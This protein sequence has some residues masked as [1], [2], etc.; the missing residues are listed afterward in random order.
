MLGFGTSAFMI[1]TAFE[2]WANDPTITTLETIAAPISDVQFPTV[3]VCNNQLENPPD[4]WGMLENVMNLMPFW[5]SNN[6]TC[7]KAKDI[8]E[9]I[10][11]LTKHV[12]DVFLD[13]L[14]H[15]ENLEQSSRI[16]KDPTSIKERQQI[17]SRLYELVQNGDFDMEKLKESP[18]DYF[19]KPFDIIMKDIGIEEK[20]LSSINCTN[21][22]LKIRAISDLIY[23]MKFSTLPLRL[24]SFLRNFL[25]FIQYDSLHPSKEIDLSMCKVWQWTCKANICKFKKEESRLHSMFENIS[26][27]MGFKE[28]FSL[29]ELPGLLGFLEKRFTPSKFHQIFMYQRC[30]RYPFVSKS[31]LEKCV[32]VWNGFNYNIMR[33]GMI[34]KLKTKNFQKIVLPISFCSLQQTSMRTKK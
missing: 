17:R 19:Q 32:N 9:D 23:D 22:C 29:Y 12:M 31:D 4:N 13:W 25:P 26:L 18:V 11:F 5:C 20:S 6:E 7:N 10:R 24:G 30:Q 33:N 2:E 28:K 1:S 3:T 8:R 21:T 15:E 27:L 14:L 34:R 16:L